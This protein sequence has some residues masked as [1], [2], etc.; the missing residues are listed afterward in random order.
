MN[1]APYNPY[2]A[3]SRLC[4]KHNCSPNDTQRVLEILAEELVSSRE[5]KHDGGE[6]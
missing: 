6:D 4:H 3:L 1:G 5:A 2:S